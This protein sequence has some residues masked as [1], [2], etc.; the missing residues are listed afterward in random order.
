MGKFEV[1][2]RELVGTLERLGLN[3]GC[4]V[5]ADAQTLTEL[6]EIVAARFQRC[7]RL[8]QGYRLALTELAGRLA[9][10]GRAA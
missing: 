3:I 10:A 7:A 5:D 4:V 6:N 2:R 8:A 9:P 1:L